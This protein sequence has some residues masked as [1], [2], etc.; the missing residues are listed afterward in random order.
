MRKDRLTA[1]AHVRVQ[2]TPILSRKKKEK[3]L[4]V[5]YR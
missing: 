5:K 2:I 3:T 4:G 1:E